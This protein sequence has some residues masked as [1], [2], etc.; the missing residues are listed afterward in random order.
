M[1]NM[2]VIQTMMKYRATL[3]VMD[4]T[5]DSLLHHAI[6]LEKDIVALLLIERGHDIKYKTLDLK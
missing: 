2:E 1:N 5:G 6:R 3:D 4:N